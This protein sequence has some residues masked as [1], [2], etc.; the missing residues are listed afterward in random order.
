MRCAYSGWFSGLILCL[1]K[2]FFC[3]SFYICLSES[4]WYFALVTLLILLNEHD[5]FNSIILQVIS[6]LWIN[7]DEKLDTNFFNFEGLLTALSREIFILPL[8]GLGL[9]RNDVKCKM[10]DK[11]LVLSLKFYYFFWFFTFQPHCAFY[12]VWP[13]YEMLVFHCL[14]SDIIN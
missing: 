7:F 14:P 8:V 13:S 12:A 5:T 6:G 10:H 3:C 2:L 1:A 9:D 11:F 4:T